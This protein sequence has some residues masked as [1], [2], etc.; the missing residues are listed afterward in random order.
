[1]GIGNKLTIFLMHNRLSNLPPRLRMILDPLVRP[2][3][4]FPPPVRI[5]MERS[6]I[7]VFQGKLGVE[8]SSI[9]A[10]VEAV[11]RLAVESAFTTPG[12][13]M[14]TID[15]LNVYADFVDPRCDCLGCAICAAREIA[16]TVGSAARL[17]AEFPGEDGGG[18]GV[19]GY[20]FFDVTLE[21]VLN[22]R[23]TIEL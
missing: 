14:I 18:L 20:D 15:A 4:C 11:G 7:D 16:H 10:V 9:I 2:S 17:V 1:M 8:V 13:K 23:Y 19:A 21:G 5:R 12:D 22:F 3:N 6:E